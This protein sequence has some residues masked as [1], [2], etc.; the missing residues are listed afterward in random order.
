MAVSCNY[1]FVA[2]IANRKNRRQNS[3]GRAVRHQKRF[4]RFVN[5]SQCVFNFKY[6]AVRVVQ[7]VRTVDFR[8]VNLSADNAEF[9]APLV[10]RHMKRVFFKFS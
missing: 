8:Y 2:L 9:I 3:A 7:I 10:S 6:V 5:F 1:Y 4:F